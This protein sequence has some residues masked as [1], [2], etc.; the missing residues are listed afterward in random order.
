MFLPIKM[1]QD[2]TL[3]DIQLFMM[4]LWR[5]KIMKI[6]TMDIIIGLLRWIMI[7]G[8]VVMCY[9]YVS[10]IAILLKDIFN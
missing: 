10:I 2:M 5:I 6:K 3:K 9:S 4:I 8:V 1:V 7:I